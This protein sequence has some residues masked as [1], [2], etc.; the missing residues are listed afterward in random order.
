MK[1]G[2]VATTRNTMI[3]LWRIGNNVMVTHPYA[4]D[5]PT[6]NTRYKIATIPVGYRPITKVDT[7]DVDVSS[8]TVYGQGRWEINTDGSVYYLTSQAT[9]LERHI[10]LCYITTN[11]MPD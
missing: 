3:N 9:F 2:S 8:N 11:A 5:V 7:D 1:T 10:C 4:F 6:A